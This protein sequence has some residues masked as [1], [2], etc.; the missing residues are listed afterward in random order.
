MLV[1]GNMRTRREYREFCVLFVKFINKSKTAKHGGK[2]E[3]DQ[4]TNLFCGL[5]AVDLHS[6]SGNMW[7]LQSCL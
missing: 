5:W 2:S 1:M 3:N 6:K 4:H 7:G